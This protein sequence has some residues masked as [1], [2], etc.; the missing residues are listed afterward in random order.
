MTVEACVGPLCRVIAAEDR[1]AGVAVGVVM[2]VVGG[3]ALFGMG[4]LR[5]R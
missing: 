2:G 5:S 3:L 4:V 1:M